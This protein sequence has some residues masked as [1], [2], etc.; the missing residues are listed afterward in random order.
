MYRIIRPS[1]D[2]YI[3]SKVI[4]K[5]YSYNSNVG[6]AA[7]F[8]LY[9]L[10][11]ES[12]AYD[13]SGSLVTS[14]VREHS[15]ALI[16]FDY[17][18]VTELDTDYHLDLS[19]SNYT[20]SLRMFDVYGGQT[21]PSNFTLELLPLAKDWLEGRGFDVVAYQHVDISNWLSASLQG[22]SPVTWSLPGA[23][24][25]GSIGDPVGEVDVYVSGNLGSGNQYL[26][27]NVFFARGD[28]EFSCDVTDLVQASISGAFTNNGFR[29]AFTSEEEED[30]K[31]YFV[32][33]FG[34]R[35]VQNKDLE[36]RLD[37]TTTADII[38][39]DKGRA[40]F[41]PITQSFF[42]FNQTDNGYSN[43]V[44][45]GGEVVGPN[46][47]GLILHH[48]KQVPITA[49]TFSIP[50]QMT[51]SYQT[52]SLATY[53]ASFTG[54]QYTV[55]TKE[56]PGI[57]NVNFVLDPYQDSTLAAYLSG[58]F[59]QTIIFDADWTNISNGQI[60]HTEKIIF[61]G[62]LGMGNVTPNKNY[63]LNIFN[64]QSVYSKQANG[65]Q[66]FKVYIQNNDTE[67]VAYRYPERISSIAVPG[68]KYRVIRAYQNVEYIPFCDATELSYDENGMF[69]DLYLDDF[70]SGYVY[71]IEF[72][73]PSG[74]GSRNDLFFRNQGW[75][76]KVID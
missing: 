61:N 74:N 23:S 44:N 68:M 29:I 47:I 66:R 56:V 38:R 6:Q 8:D 22:S 26:G 71:Q 16:Q 41:T 30:D 7:T 49:T 13:A 75:R 55:G 17:A 58:S 65:S 4:S 2:T 42:L 54:S 5:Q 67:Q 36:P 40:G 46:S 24:A 9:S 32:K 35:H 12:Y 52:K 62:Y 28:E 11:D 15:R 25:A 72:V 69:F 3:T 21:T 50:H 1:K 39:S 33:R 57:Y 43:Y 14:S 20:C 60:L 34:T 76:F 19:S 70:D 45:G 31:T 48:S 73:V 27:K 18:K 51:I 63:V 59:N 37:I 53:T 10:F 64:L